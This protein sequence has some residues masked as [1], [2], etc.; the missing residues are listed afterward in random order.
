MWRFWR[1][2]LAKILSPTK[3]PGT[4]VLLRQSVRFLRQ[5]F[6]RLVA[7][8]AVVAVPTSL[9][10]L[11]IGTEGETQL[12]A[13]FSLAALLMNLA[14]LWTIIKLDQGESVGL[15]RA[16]YLGTAS[17]VR[18]MLVALVLALQLLPFIIGTSIYA[19]GVAG[20]GGSVALVEKLLLAGLGLALTAPTLFWLTRYLFALFII[21]T[22]P[23]SPI[24]ALRTSRA[25]VKGRGFGVFRRLGLFGLLAVVVLALPSV[26][27]ILLAQGGGW[28]VG[29]QLTTTLLFLPLTNIYLYK[30]FRA[31]T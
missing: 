21:P 4:W 3:L 10:D 28:L 13:Y 27:L 31:L 29:L 14:L 23:K 12:R 25:A 15:S 5:H 8:V 1:N 24:E 18:F 20:A 19:I 22:S 17:F 6:W 26:G 16:Y 9:L 30:L 11:A 7:V 2:P